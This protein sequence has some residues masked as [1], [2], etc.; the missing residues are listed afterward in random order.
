MMIN[1][2]LARASLPLPDDAMMH[3]WWIALVAAALGKVVY[4]SR[5]TI[6]YR[7]HDSNASGSAVRR[8]PL[9][10]GLL[11][12][13][14]RPDHFDKLMEGRFKQCRALEA[15]LS[16]FPPTPESR[17]LGAFLD[18]ARRGRLGAARAAW[19]SGVLMQGTL[20]NV[21]FYLLLLK[22]RYLAPERRGAPARPKPN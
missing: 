10:D 18:G 8:K 19:R 3:D 7:Q 4:L 20:R 21:L 12:V 2:D 11:R 15:H 6:D 5:A 9:Y 13:L 22:R 1:R 14:T 16:R 17:R